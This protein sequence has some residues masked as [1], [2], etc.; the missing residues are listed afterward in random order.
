MTLTTAFP[1]R[2]DIRGNGKTL[3]VTHRVQAVKHLG[4]PTPVYRAAVQAA[5]ADLAAAIRDPSHRPLVTAE[6]GADSLRVALAAR[7]SAQTGQGQLR[8]TNLMTQQYDAIIIGAGQGGDPLARAL[9]KAGRRVALIERDAVGGTCVNRGCTP[10]KTMVASARVAYLARRASDYGVHAG[11]VTVDMAQVRQRKRD[12][13]NDFRGG[14]EKKIEKIDGLDL[15]YGEAK[16]TGPKSVEVALKDGGTQALT[17][18]QIFLNTGAR[19]TDS[20]TPRSGRRAVSGLNFGD[21]T[22]LPSRSI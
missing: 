22:G 8:D 7:E 18:A 10:T 21:G 16:F 4:D 12:I 2:R 1:L 14:T 5:M 20:K 13:V 17:A 9:A 3:H 6:D 15:I 11:P 19:P